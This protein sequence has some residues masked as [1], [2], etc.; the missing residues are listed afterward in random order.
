M[1]KNNEFLVKNF[2][3]EKLIDTLSVRMLLRNKPPRFADREEKQHF[4]TEK[5]YL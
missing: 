3:T 5:K 2:V 1:F 4:F